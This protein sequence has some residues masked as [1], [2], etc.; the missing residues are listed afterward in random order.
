MWRCSLEHCLVAFLKRDLH[1]LMCFVTW[2]KWGAVYFLLYWSANQNF[3]TLILT[4]HCSC[5][6]SN[7]YFSLLLYLFQPG[8]IIITQLLSCGFLQ[9]GNVALYIFGLT[10]N[11]GNVDIRQSVF[12][13]IENAIFSTLH[14]SHVP[15]F[16][17]SPQSFQ[18]SNIVPCRITDCIIQ[19]GCK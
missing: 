18:L 13:L 4:G 15:S 14:Y 8:L 12:R 16:I 1:C 11:L 19:H 3:Y 2:W 9:V 10:E 7:I 17:I 6:S 5:F